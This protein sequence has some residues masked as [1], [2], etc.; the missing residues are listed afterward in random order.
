MLDTNV[1]RKAKQAMISRGM[2]SS[3]HSSC[4]LLEEVML[5]LEKGKLSPLSSHTLQCKKGM[6]TVLF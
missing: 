1:D 4:Q 6:K 5:V 2:L 3:Q